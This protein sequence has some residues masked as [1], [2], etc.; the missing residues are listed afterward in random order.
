MMLAGI[1]PKE[2]AARVAQA[3]RDYVDEGPVGRRRLP[4]LQREEDVEEDELDDDLDD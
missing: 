1:A 3:L 4:V 2:R